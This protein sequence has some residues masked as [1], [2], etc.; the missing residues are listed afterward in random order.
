MTALNPKG[1]IGSTR[2]V[3]TRPSGKTTVGVP[4]AYDEAIRPIIEALRNEPRFGP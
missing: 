3:D 4:N 1:E 2:R